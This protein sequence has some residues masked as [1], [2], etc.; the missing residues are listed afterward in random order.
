MYS[1]LIRIYINYV[2]DYQ[3]WCKTSM[4]YNV[5]ANNMKPNNLLLLFF[6]DVPLERLDT[7]GLEIV[8]DDKKCLLNNTMGQTLIELGNLGLSQRD[9]ITK[10][11]SLQNEND[12]KYSNDTDNDSS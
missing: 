6:S 11:F 5:R 12:L 8:V 9:E 3:Y 2:C 7:L 1:E 4:R 10:W